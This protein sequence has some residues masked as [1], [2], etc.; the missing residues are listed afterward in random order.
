MI[1]AGK[2]MQLSSAYCS[3][4]SSMWQ[5]HATF[6]AA[7]GKYLLQGKVVASMPKQKDPEDPEV[8]Q[9]P[10]AGLSSDAIRQRL[11]YKVNPN[12]GFS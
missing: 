3:N 4:W 5:V 11:R 7:T 6:A 9:L 8:R 10:S 12:P 2:L 1:L